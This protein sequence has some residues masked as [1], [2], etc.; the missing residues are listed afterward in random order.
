[1]EALGYGVTR[2]SMVPVRGE[3]ADAA[4]MTSQLLFGEHYTVLE[5]SEDRKWLKVVNAFDSYEGWIDRK[6][7]HSIS[8]EYYRQISETEYKICTDLVAKIL[9]PRTWCPDLGTKI[10]V[11]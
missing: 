3:P 1:M 9:A 5:E 6:Q 10:L 7:H 11:L 2:L 4:E 8:K